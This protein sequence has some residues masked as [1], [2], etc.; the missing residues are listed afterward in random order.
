MVVVSGN[1]AGVSTAGAI[2][3]STATMTVVAVTGAVVVGAAV[4]G[5]V[6]VA[7]GS[8]V[9]VGAGRSAA[10]PSSPPATTSAPPTNAASAASAPAPITHGVIRRRARVGRSDTPTV[11]VATTMVGGLLDGGGG[12]TL[13]GPGRGAAA[14]VGGPNTICCSPVAGD[15]SC[16][17]RSPGGP[18]AP[19]DRTAACST[20]CDRGLRVTPPADRRSCGNAALHQSFDDGRPA[21]TADE[22]DAVTA[23]R[24]TPASVMQRRSRLDGLVDVGADDLLELVAGDPHLARARRA[25]APA[26][27]RRGATTASPWPGGPP[28]AARRPTCCQRRLV[29]HLD[30]LPG[31]GVSCCADVVHHQLVEQLAA[32]VLVAARPALDDEPAARG[33]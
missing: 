1:G 28:C 9:S 10:P 20:Q 4:V 27:R 18:V 16:V 21:R 11:G 22:V 30:L 19:P 26:D 6:V 13:V 33:R 15:A 24:S 32:D 2:V 29:G 14:G 17:V 8:V 31:L 3:V 12:G 7:R 5:V 23:D 25:A